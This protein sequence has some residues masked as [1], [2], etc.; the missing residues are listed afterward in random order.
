[1]TGSPRIF[2]TGATGVVGRWLVPM[3][4]ARRHHVTAVGRTAAKRDALAAAG[5]HPVALDLL[6]ARA[7]HRA[8][9]GHDVVINLATHLPPT[10]FQMM[11]PW[12]WRENDRV[13]RDG[14]AT[15]AAA[16]SAV[17]VRRF[18]QESFAPVYEDG[19]MRW[20]DES[21]PQRPSSISRTVLDAE[22]SAMRFGERGGTGVVLRFASFYGPDPLLRDLVRVVRLGWAPLPGAAD[23]FWSSIAQEDAASAVVAS[24]DVPSGVYNVSDDEPITRRAWNAAI[25]RAVGA[26][27]P[28]PVPTWL[29]RLGGPSMEVLSRSQ[30]ISHDKLTAASG[31]APRWPSARDG[32]PDA[33]RRLSVGRDDRERAP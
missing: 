13:R 1:M 16:A 21:W 24:L 30:R 32:L 33:V 26:R 23:A 28:R 2:V 27:P 9:E 3:L 4:V 11:L 17:G 14:S 31:W 29:T 6:D 18:I 7:A 20:L 12:A 10:T 15:L 25:A 22:R 19:G 5:A 8:L